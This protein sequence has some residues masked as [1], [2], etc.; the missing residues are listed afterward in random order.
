MTSVELIR[1]HPDKNEFQR[2]DAFCH[3][4][5]G[6][7][8]SKRVISMPQVSGRSAQ[9][10]LSPASQWFMLWNSWLKPVTFALL[11]AVVCRQFE[12][13]DFFTAGLVLA[14]FIGGC[15]SCS[16]LPIDALKV[17]GNMS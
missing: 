4:C 16:T 7:S 14:A 3:T 6:C 5:S 9:L 10:E 15:R 8:G 1:V 13:G 17:S 12:V 11:M 2:I